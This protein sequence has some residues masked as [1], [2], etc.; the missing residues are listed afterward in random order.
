MKRGRTRT[1]KRKQGGGLPNP[2]NT[3]LRLRKLPT[4]PIFLS[5]RSRRK[6]T[7]QLIHP[8]KSFSRHGMNQLLRTTAEHRNRNAYA[9]VRI[10][11]Q[12]RDD[13]LRQL[14]SFHLRLRHNSSRSLQVHI[15]RLRMSFSILCGT[16]EAT[17]TT[18]T[19]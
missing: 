1:P 18:L 17:T 9:N 19:A 7:T 12:C 14:C 16:Q 15:T 4:T 13:V 11:L 3:T 5:S 8:R 6:H 2:D 10:R